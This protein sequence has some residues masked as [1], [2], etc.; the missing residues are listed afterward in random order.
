LTALV[1][2]GLAAVLSLYAVVEAR[3]AGSGT[4]GPAPAGAGPG[5]ATEAPAPP[6]PAAVEPTPPDAVPTATGSEY[7]LTPQADYRQKYRDEVL[8]PRATANAVSYIDL[9]EPRLG[10]DTNE[11]DLTLAADFGDPVPSLVFQEGVQVAESTDADLTAADCA[12]RIRTS[13]L[14]QPAE[15][16]AQRDVRLCVATSPDRA[17]S[18]GI[19][20]RIV[21]LQ[22]TASTDNSAEDFRV[23]LNLTA[24]NVPR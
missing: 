1:V 18:E 4:A 17:I 8:H 7:E 11:A 14:P 16:A 10:A 20:R 12:N 23:S 9:D 19:P 5:A 2:A 21:A 3:D 13:A 15:V 24:W 6:P 22:V